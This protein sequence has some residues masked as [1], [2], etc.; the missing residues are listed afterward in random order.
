MNRQSV[1]GLGVCLLRARPVAVI[2]AALISAAAAGLASGAQGMLL[3]WEQQLN[4]FVNDIAYGDVVVRG[5]NGGSLVELGDAIS[6]METLGYEA[7]PRLRMEPHSLDHQVTVLG[8]DTASPAERA[9]LERHL[10]FGRLPTHGET[11]WALVSS[12]VADSFGL[13]VDKQTGATAGTVLGRTAIGVL[14][15]PDIGP[16]SRIVV[17]DIKGLSPRLPEEAPGLLELVV[18][19]PRNEFSVAFDIEDQSAYQAASWQDMDGA[20]D[21]VRD[22]TT[23]FVFVFLVLLVLVYI[24]VVRAV[25]RALVEEKAKSIAIL[26]ALGVLDAEIRGALTFLVMSSVGAGLVLGVALAWILAG[27]FPGN[28]AAVLLLPLGT[29]FVVT[30]TTLRKNLTPEPADVLRRFEGAPT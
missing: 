26:Q 17:V 18:D 22:L 3:A 8:V 12:P 9:R 25:A 27:M 6:T 19:A 4:S 16:L 13:V 11:G 21:R 2:V 10:S 23:L 24:T 28:P 5:A 1:P 15:I 30:R 14:D 7:S 29:A 20:Y